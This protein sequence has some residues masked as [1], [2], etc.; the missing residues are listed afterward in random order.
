MAHPDGYVTIVAPSWEEARVT[1][2]SELDRFW[3]NLYEERPNEGMFPL[4]EV[5]RYYATNRNA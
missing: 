5:G 3:A 4:G 1:A 2:L